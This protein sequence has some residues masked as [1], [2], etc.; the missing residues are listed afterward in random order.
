MPHHA[1]HDVQALA[2]LNCLDI[3]DNRRLYLTPRSWRCLFLPLCRL[4]RL[5]RDV[6]GSTRVTCGSER[7]LTLPSHA[8][9]KRWQ[10]GLCNVVV[11]RYRVPP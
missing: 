8:H 5:G 9:I 11:K 2:V 10:L 4:Q 1:L 6:G 3:S 7:V